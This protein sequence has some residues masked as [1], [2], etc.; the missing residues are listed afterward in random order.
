VRSPR[1]GK[2]IEK[3]GWY[4]PFLSENNI[5]LNAE[6]ISYWLN[7]GAEISHEAKM[8]LAKAAPEVFKQYSEKRQAKRMKEIQERRALRK[9][10][11]SSK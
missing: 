5:S 4:I 3:L 9:A 7:Q 1:D 6:R 8:M 11:K 10:A 2:Y